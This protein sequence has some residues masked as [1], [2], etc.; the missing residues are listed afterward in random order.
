M[1][2]AGSNVLLVGFVLFI[3]L[4]TL[5]GILPTLAVGVGYLRAAQAGLVQPAA[6]LRRQWCTAFRQLVPLSLLA[7]VLV[8]VA[9]VDVAALQY[10]E[11]RAA[12]ALSAFAL[13][14]IAV[15]LVR[16]L[17]TL[18]DLTGRPR[19][20]SPGT[21]ELLR[22][23]WAQTRSDLVGTCMLLGAGL[24]AGVLVWMLPPMSVIAGGLLAHA[25]HAAAARRAPHLP[26]T[27][28][29]AGTH[30]SSQ[31]N[32]LPAALTAGQNKEN[33]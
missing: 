14:G 10:E 8:V 17:A 24:V 32:T 15:V 3:S 7:L 27:G 21:P 1:L 11:T 12:G 20:D 30:V 29:A 2:E 9:V 22:E 26:A 25:L 23:G 5:I 13:V 16:A 4:P 19:T 6:V 28:S 18:T 33:Q 31:A